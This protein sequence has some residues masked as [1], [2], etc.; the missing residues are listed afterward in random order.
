VLFI[1]GSG[2]CPT[3]EAKPG[4]NEAR[5]ARIVKGR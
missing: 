2:K 4:R 5:D 3:H 1:F